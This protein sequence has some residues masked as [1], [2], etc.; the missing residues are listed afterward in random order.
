MTREV[1]P[2]ATRGGA[3]ARLTN[4]RAVPEQVYSSLE[5]PADQGEARLDLTQGLAEGVAV[6]DGFEGAALDLPATSVDSYRSYSY[7]RD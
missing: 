2:E 6:R 4:L 5:D 7:R 3:V 1:P